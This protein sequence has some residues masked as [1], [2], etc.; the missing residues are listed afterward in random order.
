MSTSR[1][2]LLVGAAASPLLDLVQQPTPASSVPTKPRLIDTHHHYLPPFYV[3]AV[4]SAAIAAGLGAVPM[5]SVDSSLA[6][7]DT[8]GIETAVVSISN[9]GIAVPDPTTAAALAR[10]CNDFAKKMTVDHPGRF[11][12][13]A[14]LPMPDVETSVREIARAQDE[15]QL[16][17]VG[18]L[19]NYDGKYLGDPAFDAVLEELHR[20]KTVVF[21]HPTLSPSPPFRALLPPPLLEFPH[22]TMWAIASLLVRGSFSRYS[23]IKFIF[24]HAGG[25]ML[26]IGARLPLFPPQGQAIDLLKRLYFDLALS[27]TPQTAPLLLGFVG[28]SQVLFGSDFPFVPLQYL[29]MFVNYVATLIAERHDYSPLI[30]RETAL[31][32]FP[33]LRG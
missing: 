3:D 4:G 9:P 8:F 32:L 6:T 33:Q 7:M 30:E 28:K 2:D 21:V 13:F 29:T 19:T 20:R 16:S 27:A 14:V 23:D 26:S 18:L 1:R 25:T 22:D 5:W 15:L 11:G 12:A 24:A 10:Q 31:S 17:G